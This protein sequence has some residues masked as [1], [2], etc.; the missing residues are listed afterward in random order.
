MKLKTDKKSKKWHLIISKRI[1]RLAFLSLTLI[2]A[3]A[4]LNRAARGINLKLPN[5][6][7][8]EM[9]KAGI[10][11][12]DSTLKTTLFPFPHLYAENLNLKVNGKVLFIFDR[13]DLYPDLTELLAGNTDSLS[14]I[15]V[16]KFMLHVLKLPDSPTG[17]IVSTTTSDDIKKTAESALDYVRLITHEISRNLPMC[18]KVTVSKFLLYRDNVSQ[19]QHFLSADNVMAITSKSGIITLTAKI[20]NWLNSSIRIIHWPDAAQIY[21]DSEIDLEGLA[22]VMS[23]KKMSGSGVIKIKSLLLFRLPLKKVIFAH[24]IQTGKAV[25]ARSD[26]S[27]LIKS[28]DSYSV[29]V[30]LGGVAD[31]YTVKLNNFTIILGD[32]KIQGNLEWTYRSGDIEGTMS[33]VNYIRSRSII[34]NFPF[35]QPADLSGSSLDSLRV[36]PDRFKINPFRSIYDIRIYAVLLGQKSEGIWSYFRMDLK[37]IHF[38]YMRIGGP[39]KLASVI[40][41]RD[42]NLDY[43]QF[44]FY[45]S[46]I[47]DMSDFMNFSSG[48][49]SLKMSGKCGMKTKLICSS[50]IFHLQGSDLTMPVSQFAR[51]YR[52]ISIDIFSYWKSLKV[53]S[54]IG[55]QH[56][57]LNGELENNNLL[58]NKGIL[59]TDVGNFHITGEIRP[60]ESLGNLL[61]RVTPLGMDKFFNKIPLL[62]F[63]VTSTLN[64]TA[65]FI[66]RIKIDHDKWSLV[67]LSIGKGMDDL[68][69]LFRKNSD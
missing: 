53:K 32:D 20:G 5:T 31:W 33:S 52:F 25:L 7:R 3:V 46:G 23:D 60:A 45:V 37:T 56:L 36:L 62:G 48:D 19:M 35:L 17:T 38:Y 66:M 11:P 2:F 22:R 30:Y 8:T 12:G 50:G 24:H 16:N 67:S 44:N 55:V 64:Y 1:F 61:I 42:I 40:I 41:D 47:L 57:D 69:N 63:V 65:G 29:D 13:I 39:A 58:I 51:I 18:R 9:I 15:H 54:E 34:R 28:N 68:K 10:S 43:P 4:I 59:N 6:I 21:I 26:G 27:N 49:F 14:E